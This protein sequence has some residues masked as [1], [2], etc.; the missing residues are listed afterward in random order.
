MKTIQQLLESAFRAAISRAFSI[1]ADPI[2]G[3]AQN[4][5]FGDYQANAA[6][7]LAKTIA[8]NTGEKT[9]PRAIAQKIIDALDL[10]DVHDA[11]PSIAGPGFIN[12]RLDTAWMADRLKQIA[13][14]DQEAYAAGDGGASFH[15]AANASADACDQ[16]SAGAPAR[17]QAQT[18]ASVRLG[19]DRADP[20]QRIIVDYSGPNIAKELHVGHL[21]STILGDAVARV[22]EF[23]GHVVIR[24]NHLGDWGT[25]FGMLISFLHEQQ[26]D[27]GDIQIGDLEDF[28]RAA[29]KR[30]DEDSAFQQTARQT[31]VKLQGGDAAILAAWEKI[32]DETRRHYEP[33]YGRLGV[34][35]SREN[36]RGE[37][38]YNPMLA[39]IVADLR[40]AGLAV[41]SDGATVVPLEGFENPLII[42]KTGGGF[43][44]GTTDLAA[45]RYRVDELH[46]GRI[47]YFVDSRQSQHFQQVFAAARRAGWAKNVSLEHAAFGTM[48]GADGKPFKSRDGA[49]VKLADLIDEAEQRALKLVSEKNPDLPDNDLQSIAHAVGVGGMKYADLSK[50]RIS[51]Y[52]FSFDKMLA[53]DGNTAPYLQYAFART[54]AI[55]RKAD[56]A[57]ESIASPIAA[58]ADAATGAT[59]I[60]LEASHELALAR[61]LLRFG[62]VIDQ[63]VREL[64]PH[65]LCSYLYELATR[66]SGFYENCPVLSSPEPTRASRLNLTALTSGTLAKGLELLGIEHP[67]QM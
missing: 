11:V 39:S 63:V 35:L 54:R 55:L 62:E 45:L 59:R 1:D 17:S 51:D 52:V 3:P 64:K 21:R 19:V 5:A 32:V 61:H 47:I 2:V 40:A 49:L 65:H 20:P 31:V 8:A 46:A 9:N 41:E 34:K 50:D 57:A 14:A 44:Y 23:A 10:G 27:G 67:Q 12:V 13:R 66:F 29:K 16:V 30:F 37:S 60:T 22:L 36:E 26:P 58:P 4:E 43:L 6:M 33:L 56:L 53:M 42:E 28:Y 25:Q 18:P 15:A 48:L 24:Q 38:F 7:G